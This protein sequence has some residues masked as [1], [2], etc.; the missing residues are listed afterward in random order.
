M[1]KKEFENDEFPPSALPGPE[2]VNLARRVLCVNTRGD[3]ERKAL[4]FD[5]NSKLKI[6][7]YTSNNKGVKYL[8][9]VSK[10]VEP[11]LTQKCLN[12]L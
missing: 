10:V 8:N 4:S 12:V 5:S 9:Q 2:S 6:V 7:S 3:V 11:E 1:I